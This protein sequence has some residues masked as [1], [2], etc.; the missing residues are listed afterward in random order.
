M[1]NGK[2]FHEGGR[3]GI[4]VS[5]E[6]LQE[7]IVTGNALSLNNE[8][9]TLGQYFAQGGER[10]KLS[11]SQIRNVL[12]K[13]QR[14]KSF[15]LNKLQLLRPLLAYAAGRHGGKVKELQ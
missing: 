15:E 13:L 6:S 14:M 9:N 7:I 5:R 12:D 3:P 8:A 11:S 4:S 2:K 10:D 1:P